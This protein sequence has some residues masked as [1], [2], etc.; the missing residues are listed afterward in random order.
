MP[1]D[2]PYNW[3]NKTANLLPI[4]LVALRGEVHQQW[5]ESVSGCSA[6]A[7]AISLG[8]ALYKLNTLLSFLSWMYRRHVYTDATKLTPE[9]IKRK[10]QLTQQPGPD[11]PCICYREP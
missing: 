10:H 8:Q 2:T 4:V 3:L 5:A 1:Q 11:L 9:F 6:S 7:G